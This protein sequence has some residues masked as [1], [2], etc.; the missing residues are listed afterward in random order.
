MTVPRLR[1]VTAPLLLVAVLGAGLALVTGCG[2]GQEAGAALP[3]DGPTRGKGG[4]Q[5]ASPSAGATPVPSSSNGRPGGITGQQYLQAARDA[6]AG[7]TS[8][9]ITGTAVRGADAYVV[10]ARLAGAGGG[11]ATITTSGQTVD[12]IRIGGDAYVGGDLAFWQ[13]VTGDPARA[14][15]MVGS[16]VRTSA[17]NGNF[18]SFVA[19][20]QPATYAAVLPAPAGPA[21]VGAATT[22]D[23]RGAVAV[24]DSA[25]T[26]LH[27]A[28]TGPAYP[29][30]LDGLAGGQVVF[31]DFTDYGQPVQLT[32]PP[33]P[34][35][36]GGG[37]GS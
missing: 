15:S 25:G 32:P 20:T 31:L 28:T 21:T 13:S 24:R 3:G 18:G 37:I 30:R 1:T 36:T 27:V 7:A 2:T 9:H 17:T 14:R 5:D 11:T 34:E 16:Y 8:V 19:F 22:I 12:V 33:T 26:T 4:M 10:D 29:L 35:V 6:F 23:G